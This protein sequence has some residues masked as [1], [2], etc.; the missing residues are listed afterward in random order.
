MSL[1]AAARRVAKLLAALDRKVAFA[2]SCT[3]G[4]VSASLARVPGISAYHCGGVVTYRNETKTAY[5][6]IS[7]QLLDRHGPVS[8]VVAQRMAEG[9]LK[10]TPEAWCAASVTGHLGPHAPPDLDGVVFIGLAHRAT[11]RGRTQIVSTVEKLDCPREL[12]RFGARKAGGGASFRVTGESDRGLDQV[13][14]FGFA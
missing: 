11:H 5:L 10:Q 7:P 6:G 12:A 14:Y 13:S 2:E 4:L 1:L 9:V 8:E 3:A